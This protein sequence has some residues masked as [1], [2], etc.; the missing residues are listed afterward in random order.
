MSTV[1]V[2]GQLLPYT[3]CNNRSRKKSREI[4]TGTIRITAHMVTSTLTPYRLLVC[5]RPTQR[6]VDVGAPSYR[7]GRLVGELAIVHARW[8]EGRVLV[9]TD[10]KRP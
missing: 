5:D 7:P 8:V 10:A 1:G 3:D 4:P 2:T 9:F 6:G